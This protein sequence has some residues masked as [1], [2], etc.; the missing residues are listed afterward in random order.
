MLVSDYGKQN[1]IPTNQNAR[2]LA[3]MLLCDMC[4][5]AEVPSPL[6]TRTC[7][8]LDVVSMS[9]IMCDLEGKGSKDNQPEASSAS[10]LVGAKDEPDDE[11]MYC[12]FM[13]M[14][15]M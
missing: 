5:C 4:M 6:Q 10:G 13:L 2:L 15:N 1:I 3:M 14:V 8:S 11:E 9:D 7:F 12:D